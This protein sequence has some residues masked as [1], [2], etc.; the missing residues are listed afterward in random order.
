M[1]SNVLAYGIHTGTGTYTGYVEQLLVPIEMH[2]RWL[3]AGCS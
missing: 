3:G 2:D 1:D